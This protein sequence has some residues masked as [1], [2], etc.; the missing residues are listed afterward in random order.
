[1]F[2]LLDAN[3]DAVCR[4]HAKLIHVAGMMRHTAI[5]RMKADPPSRVENAENWVSRVVRGK[6]EESSPEEHRQFSYVPLPS[7]GHE[8]ADA[9]I[10]NVMVVAPLGMERE[11]EYLAAR[12]SGE[13]LN[14]TAA[15]WHKCLNGKDL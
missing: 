8:H 14:S 12:L 4:P 10:R 6:R 5:E 7:I 9:M 15:L 1:M 13:P 2:R 3:G 11:L